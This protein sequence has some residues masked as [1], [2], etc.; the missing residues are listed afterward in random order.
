MSKDD[1]LNKLRVLTDIPIVGGGIKSAWERSK[2]YWTISCWKKNE[3]F[4][5]GD[6][7]TEPFRVIQIS[8]SCINYR[9]S[10]EPFNRSDCGRVI[11]GN[12]DQNKKHLTKNDPLY[13]ALKVRY[14]QGVPWEDIG[15]YTSQKKRI[16]NGK[17]AWGC[18]TLHGLE[19]RYKNLDE[20]YM[21]MKNNGYVRENKI[22]E[23]KTIAA[24][25]DVF[26]HISRRGELL[27]AGYGNHR[28]RLAKLLNLNEIS[29]RII[30]RHSSWQ[31]IRNK[32]YK[33]RI[34]PKKFSLERSHPDLKY[35]V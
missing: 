32:I 10:P 29:I 12:W 6:I 14:K 30:V 28:I 8:P 7:P 26:V 9:V 21:S 19:K 18:T 22:G 13:E 5:P 35:I 17:S 16:H 3:K 34:H 23:E 15:F 27:F 33:E 31:S 2:Y 4:A 1:L 20:V 24:L 25:D 11:G